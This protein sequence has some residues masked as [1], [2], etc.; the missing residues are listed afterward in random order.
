MCPAS[1]TERSTPQRLLAT[2]GL[3][4]PTVSLRVL[5]VETWHLAR[6]SWQHRSS[7][8]I[9]RCTTSSRLVSTAE[10][11]QWQGVLQ[12]PAQLLADLAHGHVAAWRTG[13]RGSRRHGV[14][15]DPPARSTC[16]RKCLSGSCGCQQP[17]IHN[18]PYLNHS[19]SSSAALGTVIHGISLISIYHVHPSRIVC[20]PLS[21]FAILRKKCAWS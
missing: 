9:K 4:W 15:V 19:Q 2:R 11:F 17:E 10:L 16:K 3:A 7:I 6:F 14:F 1:V 20:F 12:Q 13:D 8:Q 18:G 21:L 5:Q